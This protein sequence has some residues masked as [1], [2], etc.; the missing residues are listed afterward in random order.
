MRMWLF[1]LSSLFVANEVLAEDPLP[2]LKE[3]RDHYSATWDK[4]STGEYTV[5]GKRFQQDKQY[6]DFH[7]NIEI[8]AAFDLDKNWLRFDRTEDERNDEK[9]PQILP[10]GTKRC[11]I[12]T[13]EGEYAHRP[14]VTINFVR[15]KH[16]TFH[17]GKYRDDLARPFDF[18]TVGTGN[19]REMS[20]RKDFESTKNFFQEENWRLFTISRLENGVIRLSMKIVPKESDPSQWIYHRDFDPK[21]GYMCVGNHTEVKLNQ[22]DKWQI[23]EKTTLTWIKKDNISLP[24]KLF[25]ERGDKKK[26]SYESLEMN[27]TWKSIN[28]PVPYEVFTHRGMNIPPETFLSFSDG[29]KSESLGQLGDDPVNA[30]ILLLDP[31]ED[32]TK[33]K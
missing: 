24:E 1:V 3:I 6:G 4:V 15:G 17:S 19:A 14:G 7:G 33:K 26:Q 30:R 9:P 10:D 11:C 18:R 13:R 27:F 28:K 21:H 31:L 32:P 16:A 20:L 8:E 5:K 2:T 23:L 12:S 25:F 22:D 29:K